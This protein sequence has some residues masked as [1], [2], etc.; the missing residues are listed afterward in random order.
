MDGAANAALACLHA[1]LDGRPSDGEME[2]FVVLL[3]A[4]Y[5]GRI[6][7]PPAAWAI[8]CACAAG[9]TVHATFS[10]LARGAAFAAIRALTG[11]GETDAASAVA[12]EVRRSLR[13]P[14]V[15]RLASAIVDE[16]FDLA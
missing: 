12:R 15:E 7:N 3:G 13:L 16:H 8:Y 11:A 6:D 14:T 2:A 1:S 5:N 10:Y 9:R 4:R